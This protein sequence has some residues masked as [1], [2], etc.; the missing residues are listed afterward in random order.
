MINK[1]LQKIIQR[2]PEKKIRKRKNCGWRTSQEAGEETC[3]SRAPSVS[4]NDQLPPLGP[5]L[6]DT[7]LC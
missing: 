1:E 4:E 5:R 3:Q 7:L 2:K 6:G